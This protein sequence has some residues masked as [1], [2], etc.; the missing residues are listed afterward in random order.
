VRHR[1]PTPDD[2]LAGKQLTDPAF[3]EVKELGE[4]TEDAP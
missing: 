3:Y 1:L 2:V 4:F